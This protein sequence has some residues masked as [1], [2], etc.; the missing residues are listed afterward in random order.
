VSA[1]RYYFDEHVSRAIA[2][3]LTRRGIDVLL[4]VDAGMAGRDDIDHLQFATN[5]ARSLY[6]NDTD[7]LALHASGVSHAG[8]I[9][10]AVGTA[11]RD[12]IDGLEM[13]SRVYTAEEMI[14]RLE[15]L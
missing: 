8:I 10:A 13:I 4:A 14:D 9:Y 6:S 12:A 2:K 1:V 11:F 15:Y 5:Q 7:F 3:G